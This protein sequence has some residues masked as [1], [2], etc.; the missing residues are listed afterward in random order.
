MPGG[1]SLLTVRQ[2]LPALCVRA[3]ERLQAAL[4][5]GRMNISPL[6]GE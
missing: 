2:W 5:H 4:L 6:H 1:L 3:F